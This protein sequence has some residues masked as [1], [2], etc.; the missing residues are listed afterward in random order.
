MSES[1]N[2]SGIRGD[3]KHTSERKRW[4]ENKNIFL[5]GLKLMKLTVKKDL[6]HYSHDSIGKTGN[7]GVALKT[8]GNFNSLG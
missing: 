1:K 8:G 3:S 5:A 2:P 4:G 7:P 6:L